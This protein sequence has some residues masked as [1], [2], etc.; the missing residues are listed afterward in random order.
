MTKHPGS[1]FRLVARPLLLVLTL[2]AIGGCGRSTSKNA[3]AADQSS[4]AALPAGLVAGESLDAFD[5]T[6]TDQSGRAVTLASY[7]GRPMVLAM[8]YT[9]CRSAC[10]LLL[11]SLRGFEKK[12]SPA[13]RANT[14][15]VL[16]TLDPSHDTPDTLLAF[17]NT[18][19][20]DGSRWRLLRGS[21][22]ATAEL[23]AILGVKAR[24]D[25]NGALAHSSNVY[26]FDGASVLR[27]ALVGLGADPAE[28]LVARAVLP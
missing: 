4:E 9:R 28:L 15:F 8:I 12:L 19:G 11:A 18:R 10:P 23:A 25:G 5:S 14:W 2:L 17:V 7:H 22:E 27:H 21:R 20:L 24:D 1:T 13:Q 6:F 26:L 3:P 16:V